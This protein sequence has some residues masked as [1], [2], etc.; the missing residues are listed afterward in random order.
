M[1]GDALRKI[2][3]AVLAV[4]LIGALIYQAITAQT[5][6]AELATLAGVAVTFYFTQT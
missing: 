4:G 6:Q 3:R 2:V 5:V 1:T